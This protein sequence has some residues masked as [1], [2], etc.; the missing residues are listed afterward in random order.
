MAISGVAI[1]ARPP[2]PAPPRTTVAISFVRQLFMTPILSRRLEFQAVYGEKNRNF[3]VFLV[4]KINCNCS[5]SPS[6][7]RGWQ[8]AEHD[9]RATFFAKTSMPAKITPSDFYDVSGA[10]K[11]K[12]YT[13]SHNRSGYHFVRD[14]ARNNTTAEDKPIYLRRIHFLFPIIWVE[15]MVVLSFRNDWANGL[16]Q[17]CAN[18]EADTAACSSAK[19]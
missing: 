19:D 15:V 14:Y 18:T 11:R 8:Q 3:F 10:Q 7:S 5:A 9:H 13:N 17:T 4:R 12:S 16:T 1:N 6:Y 2:R